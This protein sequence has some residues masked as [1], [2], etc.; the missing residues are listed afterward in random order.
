MQV[1]ARSKKTAATH[2]PLAYCTHLVV[3]PLSFINCCPSPCLTAIKNWYKLMDAS[4][5][6]LRPKKDLMSCS[7]IASG[8]SS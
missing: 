7:L 4:M 6:T 1:R 3:S 8:A 5:A 2:T